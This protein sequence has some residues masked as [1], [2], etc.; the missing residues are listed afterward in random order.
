MFLTKNIISHRGIHDNKKIFE[1]TLEA[2][3][4]AVNKGYIIEIDVHLTK[5]NK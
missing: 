3:S 1:N 2:I 5:D 4:L